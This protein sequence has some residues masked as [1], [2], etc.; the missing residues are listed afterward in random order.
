[1]ELER[2][3][4]RGIVK[5]SAPG[6]LILTGE[7]AV[8][9]GYPAV[10]AAVNRR[11][12]INQKHEVV[13]D[14]PIGC[15]MGSSAAYAVALAALET[16]LQGRKLDR[17]EINRQAYER[18]KRSHGN[19][20]GVDNTICTYGGF[21]WYRKEIEGFKVFSQIEAKR[22]FPPILVHNT[23]KPVETTREMVE[24]VGSLLQK[25]P[26]RVIRIWEQIQQVAKGFLQYLT[27]EFSPNLV[28]LIR[29]N[30][31]LL[32]ELGVV[33]DSTRALIR[34]VRTLGGAAKISG[35]GGRLG[36]SG[37]ILLYH[38]DME[39]LKA[40]LN[41]AGLETFAVKLGEEGVRDEK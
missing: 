27:A 30:E 15:G 25:S 11:L 12:Q 9:Y 20:S 24:M 36:A 10:V 4:T 41:E 29:E 2:R 33:S 3:M 34:K 6:K 32:E 19:P 40:Y 38:P 7:H 16:K 35:A 5:V 8:V 18:E 26:Q 37:I 17:E 28:E 23:G 13:S 39:K 14:I 21:L 31:R 22:K 1:M